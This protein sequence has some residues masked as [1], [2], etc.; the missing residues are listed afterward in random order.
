MVL[1]VGFWLFVLG[2]WLYLLSPSASAIQSFL[3]G[4]P[5]A[6]RRQMQDARRKTLFVQGLG[7]G[8]WQLLQIQY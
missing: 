4:K 8:S 1:A 7:D 3:T 2:C 6:E 5:Q